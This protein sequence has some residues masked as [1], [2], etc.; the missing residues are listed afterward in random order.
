MNPFLAPI[1]VAVI[2]LIIVMFVYQWIKKQP[3]GTDVMKSISGEIHKGA[4]AYLKQQYAVLSI[5]LIIVFLLLTFFLPQ[6]GLLTAVTFVFGGICSLIAGFIGMNAATMANARTAW[7][8]NQYGQGK[9]LSVAFFGGSVMGLAVASIG[10]LGLSILF[11]IFRSPA[12]AAIINGFAMGASSMALFMRI[13]GGI[14]T[15]AADVGA[16]LVGKVEAGIPEDDPRNPATIADNVGDNVG[17]VAGLGADIFESYVNSV[18]ASLAIAATATATMFYGNEILGNQSGFMLLPLILILVG[19]ISSLIGVF[20]MPI[21]KKID[22]A[23]ALRYSMFIAAGL[24]LIFAYVTIKIMVGDIRPFWAIL[25]GTVS[26]TIIG[27]VTEYYTGSKPVRKI[28]DAAL[29]GPGTNAI[30]GSDARGLVCTSIQ[31]GFKTTIL[32]IEPP[33]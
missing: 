30:T 13:G 12:E 25:V 27:L 11:A 32:L 16:D 8:A 21:L 10:L 4:M 24:F 2:G 22:P 28:A 23:A 7:S 1:V 17:D 15:K 3:A 33:A 20:S 19:L 31:S 9:A 6:N 18:V 5:F 14:Y 26:G 29:T